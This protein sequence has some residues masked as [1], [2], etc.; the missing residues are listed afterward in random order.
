MSKKKKSGAR[1]SSPAALLK[2]KF[3]KFPNKPVGVFFEPKKRAFYATFGFDQYEAPSVTALEQ[4]I[5]K[6]IKN[7]ATPDA[8]WVEMIKLEIPVDHG[9]DAKWGCDAGIEVDLGR[10]FFRVAAGGKVMECP[11]H[12]KEKERAKA[13]GYACHELRDR[14]VTRLNAPIFVKSPATSWHGP[15]LVA[16]LPFDEDVWREVTDQVKAMRADWADYVAQVASGGLDAFLSTALG[17]TSVGMPLAALKAKSK[18]STKLSSPADPTLLGDGEGLDA[19]RGKSHGPRSA[20]T[21]PR[22]A[23]KKKSTKSTPST[24]STIRPLINFQGEGIRLSVGPLPLKLQNVLH[25]QP[26]YS[27]MT[28]AHYLK[29]GRIQILRG[30]MA[31]PEYTSV[32][33]LQHYCDLAAEKSAAPLFANGPERKPAEVGG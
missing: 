30:P 25:A 23:S 21:K 28:G 31:K 11:S 24:Q 33:E 20:T 3:D 18:K 17:P 32:G 7:G 9:R 22:A 12:F 13:Q 4:K 5:K 2:L 14:K 16:L 29:D 19:A 1:P 15:S 6:A 26:A 27:D 8:G 10:G